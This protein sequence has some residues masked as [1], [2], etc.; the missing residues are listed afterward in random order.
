M[1]QIQLP[2][3]KKGRPQMARSALA[4]APEYI[5]NVL[6]VEDNSSDAY[7]VSDIMNHAGSNYKV[8]HVESQSQA[9]EILSRQ[10]FDV[11]LLDL[12]LPDAS[13]FSALVDIQ[14]YSP[15]MPVLI[16]TGLNDK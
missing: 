4:K 8:T 14:K 6:L 2:Q 15:G 5:Q 13:G 12:S 16:L 7:M 10:S 3:L 11:C 1:L 9:I